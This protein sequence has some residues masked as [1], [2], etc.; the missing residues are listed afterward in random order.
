MI[1]GSIPGLSV[2][3]AMA[4]LV[5]FSYGLKMQYAVAI[6]MGLYMVGVYSG[7]ISAIL[8]NI[9]GA[10]SN[11][12]TAFDGYPLAKNGKAQRA[13]K[14]SAFYSFTGGLFGLI[15]LAILVKPM[16]S[17]ALKIHPIDYFLLGVTGLITVGTLSSKNVFKGIISASFGI[18]CSLIGVNIVTGMPRFTFGVQ[19]LKAGIPLTAALIGLFGFSEVLSYKPN[20]EINPIQE[21]TIKLKEITKHL[22]KCLPF[23]FIGTLIGALPGAGT[24][25][26]SLLA[27]G[28]A[29]KMDTNP[30]TPFGKGNELGIVSCETANNACVGGAL[31][32]MLTLGIPGDSVT[33]I[34]MAVFMIHG[35][36][37][38]PLFLN[39]GENIFK[40]MIISG[41]IATFILLILGFFFAP[42]FSKA[43]RIPQ[44]IL[45]PIIAL[46]CIFG[47]FATNERIFDVIIMLVF[48]II[49][50]TFKK[51]K[52]GIAPVTL[53]LVLGKMMEQNLIRTIAI[54]KTYSNPILLYF[55]PV[56]LFLSAVIIF[57][58]Y[59][60]T[61]EAKNGF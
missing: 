46:L 8:L 43:L 20:G 53:G 48:G 42:F 47:S 3:M 50:Y 19:M 12:V 54:A 6:M 51:Y 35:L 41:F 27:Y 39:S 31:I 32:P 61:R 52:F 57:V 7:S 10:P 59:F 1:V 21:E 55:R 30:P 34:M 16:T 33:A 28:T 11:V 44:K 15:C 49:G 58:I 13:L 45:V 24:P 38:G 4:I 26:A 22:K 5:S 9:P 2:S 56:T 36:Q 14:L 17:L 60:K 25:V 40:C 23:C 18:F 29:K 37:P